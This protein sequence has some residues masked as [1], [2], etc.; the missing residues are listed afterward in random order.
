MSQTLA[1]SMSSK[2]LISAAFGPTDRA[3]S[4]EMRDNLL[5]P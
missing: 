5:G 3:A 4:A 1:A 2:D